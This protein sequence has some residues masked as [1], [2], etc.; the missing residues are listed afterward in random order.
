MTHLRDYCDQL[1]GVG[2]DEALLMQ[3]FSQSLCGDALDWYPSHETRQCPS[4]NALAKEFIDR[5]SYNV[6]FVPD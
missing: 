3:L 1:V 6:E 4:W 5:F 2:R